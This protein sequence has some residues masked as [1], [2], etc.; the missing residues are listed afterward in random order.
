MGISDIQG[1]YVNAIEDG[2]GAEKAGIEEGDIIKKVDRVNITKFSELTGYLSSKR[3][4]DV[5][6]VMVER[7]GDLVTL[8]VTLMKNQTLQ[9]PVMGF[10]VKDLTDKD[11]K[12]FN[13]KEGVKITGVPEGYRRYQLEGKVI[14]AVDEEEVT[15]IDDAKAVFSKVSRYGRTS[16]TLIDEDG[17]RERL[18]FQ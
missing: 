3:P 16:I 7:D 9:V 1:V 18:I 17:E 6:E 5:V 2:S 15:N 11:K 8:P 12:K 4:K 10:V 13:R 14:I